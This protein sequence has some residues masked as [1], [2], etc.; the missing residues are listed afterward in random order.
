MFSSRIRVWASLSST[1]YTYNNKPNPNP[2]VFDTEVVVYIVLT[3]FVFSVLESSI[4]V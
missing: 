1:L 3:D 2:W 4:N